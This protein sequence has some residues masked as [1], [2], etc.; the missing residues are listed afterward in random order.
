MARL[1]AESGIKFALS[2]LKMYQQA[3]N[4]LGKNQGTL[5]GVISPIDIEQVITQ[6][7]VLPVPI[8]EGGMSEIQKQTIE[9]FNQNILLKGT[10]VVSIKS[11]SAFLNPNRLIVVPVPEAIPGNDERGEADQG[12]SEETSDDETPR[13]LRVKEEFIKMITESLRRERETN[14]NYDTLYATL[15]PERLVGELMFYV[16]APDRYDDPMSQDFEGLYAEA[17]AMPKHGP[18]TSLDELYLLQGWN[19]AI[20][21]LIK[22]QVTIHATDIISINSITEGQLRGMFP[23]ITDLQVEEFFKRRD[24]DDELGI[25]PRS[26]RSLQDFENFI[27]NELGVINKDAFSERISAL[28]RMGVRPDAA[29]KLFEVSSTGEVGRARYTIEAVVDIPLAPTTLPPSE[30]KDPQSQE[31]ERAEQNPSPSPS[32]S[33]SGTNPDEEKEGEDKRRKK[34]IFL[35][36]RV[37][38]IKIL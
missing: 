27:V 1:S 8:D 15:E 35:E 38:E 28:E 10:L 14:I 16:N 26:F 18:L 25:A 24:G 19:D 9:E 13:H 5:S 20:I 29:G 3:R 6:P 4:T 36:P 37:V 11:V 2:K 34:N 7:F 23:D 21:D 12:G 31:R 22:D 30:E 33:V 32:E 17:D